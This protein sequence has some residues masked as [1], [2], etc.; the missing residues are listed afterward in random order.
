MYFQR[1][2][3]GKNNMVLLDMWNECEKADHFSI[4]FYQL[5]KLYPP[6]KKPKTRKLF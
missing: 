2:L 6:R 1:N 5:I 3:A 4:R